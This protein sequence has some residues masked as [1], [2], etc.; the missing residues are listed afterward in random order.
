MDHI[1]DLISSQILAEFDFPASGLGKLASNTPLPLIPEN[2]DDPSR[3]KYQFFFLALISMRKLL[4]R[5]LFYL[6]NRGMSRYQFFPPL[7]VLIRPPDHSKDDQNHNSPAVDRSTNFSSASES[8]IQELDRQLEE[9]RMFLPQ[10]LQFP[11]YSG[12]ED[13]GLPEPH[14][15]RTTDQRLLGHLMARYYSAK[16]II[17]RPF[18]YRTLHCDQ[19]TLLS[20]TD[21]FGTSTAVGSAFMSV[22]HSGIFHEPLEL[23]LHPINSCR[24]YEVRSWARIWRSVS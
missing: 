24:R 20:E 6:Y 8:V 7:C 21:K 22:I 18:V 5:I 14:E 15:P 9:W 11:S 13:L 3:A 10:G 17:H 23:L 2:S 1:S 12:T 16:S 19:F 4:N